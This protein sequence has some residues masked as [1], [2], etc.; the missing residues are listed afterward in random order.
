MAV[1]K[2]DSVRNHFVYRYF[3]AAGDLLYVG[4][5]HR[6]EIRWKEHKSS[7]PGMCAAVVKVTMSGP[8]SYTKAREIERLAIRAENP[9]C[10]WTPEK[11]REKT[12]RN[13][14]IDRHILG[15]RAQG[16][17][18]S[19]AIHRAVSDADEV[20]P[21]PMISPYDLPVRA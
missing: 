9:I 8:Y 13:Q 16:L 21:D 4:C 1:D 15:Y 10:G 18:V 20:W 6:P 14:W 12:Q 19:D 5:S 2:S 7:R 3:D 17:A 11:H